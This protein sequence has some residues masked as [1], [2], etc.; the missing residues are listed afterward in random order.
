MSVTR[1]AAPVRVV[2]RALRRLSAHDGPIVAGHMAFTGFMSLFPFMIFLA[3]LAS[4]F[5]S[6]QDAASVVDLMFRF[7]PD[8]VAEVLAPAVREVVGARRGGLLTLGLLGT[9]WAAAGGVEALREALNRAYE[10]HERRPLWRRR[11]QSLLVVVVG[12]FAFLL[13]SLAVL[14]G[15]LVWQLADR[16]FELPAEARWLWIGARYAFAVGVLVL[17]LLLLHHVLPNHDWPLRAVLR[18]VLA[19]A[20]LWL[21]AASLFSWYLATFAD[22][23]VTYGSLGGVVVV[24][25]FFCLSALLFIFG[26]E[27]NAAIRA[28]AAERA[29]A[30]PAG[31]DD[32]RAEALRR[33]PASTR[34]RIE[35]SASGTVTTPSPSMVTATTTASTGSLLSDCTRF[36]IARSAATSGAAVSTSSTTPSSP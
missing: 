33:A 16:L 5:G 28:A 13:L 9:V 35:A 36:E 29:A 7:L 23:S 4:F 31:R 24:L 6:E 8:D 1:A 17:V 15:P 30:R 25:L 34:T 27:I 12:G 14:L 22:Y 19:T 32:T 2:R 21:L 3:A 26:A 20:V 18:G 10:V 11:L